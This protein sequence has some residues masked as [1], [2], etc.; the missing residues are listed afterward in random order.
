[1]SGNSLGSNPMQEL[2][3]QSCK[4][5]Y[6]GLDALLVALRWPA[7]TRRILLSGWPG[8][9]SQHSIELPKV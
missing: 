4:D 6:H 5:K 3:Q 9:D 2:F 7:G 8:Q 1:M